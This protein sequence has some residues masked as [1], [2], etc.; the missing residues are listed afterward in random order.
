MGFSLVAKGVFEE[1]L[2]TQLQN[3]AGDQLVLCPFH[4]DSATPSLAVDVQRGMFYCFGGCSEPRGG[5]YVTFFAKFHQISR[6]EARNHL[7][8][9]GRRR[10]PKDVLAQAVREEFEA[11]LEFANGEYSR[12]HC[13]L[14]RW[15]RDLIKFDVWDWDLLQ[16][17]YFDLSDVQYA[18]DV[19]EE[20]WS[21]VRTGGV[22]PSHKAAAERRAF[23]LFKGHR[24][25]G[26]W[27]LDHYALVQH[28][29]AFRQ[30]EVAARQ[31]LDQHYQQETALCRT[32]ILEISPPL[33]RTPLT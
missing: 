12:L 3:R 13:G 11:F 14:E 2:R 32:P 23:E 28:R 27:T 16:A 25:H 21:V 5:D 33:T 26:L 22:S 17:A 31:G 10:D 7:V 18:L 20:Y 24:D 1:I 29:R 19:V 6:V 15:V 9:L 4:L 30:R 8:T